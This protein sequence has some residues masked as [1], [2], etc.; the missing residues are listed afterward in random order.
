LHA[1]AYVDLK[2]VYIWYDCKRGLFGGSKE[3]GAGG[4]TRMKGCGHYR[5]RYTLHAFMK[6]IYW[7]PLKTVKKEGEQE[8]G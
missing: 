3:V 6:V 8:R 2:D 5:C 7:I 4:K 1:F